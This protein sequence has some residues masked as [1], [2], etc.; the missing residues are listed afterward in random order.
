[1]LLLTRAQT[2]SVGPYV[3]PERERVRLIAV[4]ESMSRKEER[5]TAHTVKATSLLLKKCV[6][7]LT[8]SKI[9][10]ECFV[11]AGTTPVGT[12]GAVSAAG[13]SG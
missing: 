11:Y 2:E 12:A 6:S 10:V 9:D 13:V 7:S 1:M 5:D 3:R 4:S 8:V